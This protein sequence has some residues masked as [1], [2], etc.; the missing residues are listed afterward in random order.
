MS[1]LL[2]AYGFLIP[3][4]WYSRM[5]YRAKIDDVELRAIDDEV[6]FMQDDRVCWISRREVWG[7][8]S[9][10]APALKARGYRLDIHSFSKRL[11]EFVINPSKIG[12]EMF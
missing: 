8:L 6:W 7:S 1:R 4:R 12:E 9:K 5:N 2:C 3:E 11:R 10:V